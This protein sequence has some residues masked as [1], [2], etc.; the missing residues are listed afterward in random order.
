MIEDYL[1]PERI[2]KDT[3]IKVCPLGLK[4]I[5]WDTLPDFDSLPDI[6]K[7]SVKLTI[8]D[9]TT[10]ES[11]RTKDTFDSEST[12]LSQTENRDSQNFSKS[13]KDLTHHHSLNLRKSKPWWSSLKCSSLS[14]NTNKVAKFCGRKRKNNEHCEKFNQINYD[15]KNKTKVSNHRR[16]RSRKCYNKQFGTHQRTKFEIPEIRF[17]RTRTENNILSKSVLSMKRDDFESPS[18]R[19]THSVSEINF[20]NCPPPPLNTT[21]YISHN[22]FNSNIL[23]PDFGFKSPEVQDGITGGINHDT[24]DSMTGKPG[25]FTITTSSTL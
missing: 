24:M 12:F 22:Y 16:K 2:T 13:W 21:Q 10:E 9:I 3:K 5:S 11:Q 19:R 15:G 25:S 8:D 14:R 23:R 17:Q 20:W 18:L 1:T 6:P 7:L 4:K